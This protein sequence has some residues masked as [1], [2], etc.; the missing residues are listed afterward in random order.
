[1]GGNSLGPE[2]RHMIP[3]SPSLQS[4]CT[5]RVERRKSRPVS[6]LLPI[7]LYLAMTSLNLPGRVAYGQELSPA[8]ATNLPFSGCREDLAAD[9]ALTDP[10]ACISDR[11]TALR[12]ILARLQEDHEAALARVPG[13]L[14]SPG[15][16]SPHPLEP[17]AAQY[18]ESLRS[19]LDAVVMSLI[20]QSTSSE[21]N[22]AVLRAHIATFKEVINLFENL[23]GS[24][25]GPLTTEWNVLS[26]DQLQQLQERARA[27]LVQLQQSVAGIYQADLASA[28][29][30][31][32][33]DLKTY[34]GALKAEGASRVNGRKA[35][36]KINPELSFAQASTLDP[37]LAELSGNGWAVRFERWLRLNVQLQKA[38]AEK[39]ATLIGL[40]MRLSE[41]HSIDAKQRLSKNSKQLRELT[42]IISETHFPKPPPRGKPPEGSSGSI[43]PPQQPA[44]GGR[45]PPQMVAELQAAAEIHVKAAARG[46]QV[47]LA[48]SKARMS[49]ATR[50]FQERLGQDKSSASQ[51]LMAA[52]SESQL[53]AL[54]EDWRTYYTTAAQN[55]HGAII[56]LDEARVEIDHLDKALALRR[57]RDKAS[58]GPKDLIRRAYKNN[59]KSFEREFDL[60]LSHEFLVELQK[61]S[62]V[63]EPY[64]ADRRIPLL[65]RSTADNVLK[66]EGTLLA[67]LWNDLEES[68]GRTL[69]YGRGAEATK[70][71]RKLMIAREAVKSAAG[72][73]REKI[74]ARQAVSPNALQ[75]TLELIR[76][77]PDG[78]GVA[79]DSYI[80]LAEAAIYDARTSPHPTSN[81]AG[82]FKTQNSLLSQDI[83]IFP[84][85]GASDF[86][87]L[88]KPPFEERFP[89]AA[90]WTHSAAGAKA[91][92]ERAPGGII[93][94]A[95]M[96]RKYLGCLEEIKIDVR[97]G[98]LKIKWDGSWREMIPHVTAETARAAWAYVHDPRVIAIDMSRLDHRKNIW[99]NNTEYMVYNL[100]NLHPALTDRAIGLDLIRADKIIFGILNLDYYFQGAEAAGSIYLKEVLPD[101]QGRKSMIT[102]STVLVSPSRSSL[103]VSVDPVLEVFNVPVPKGRRQSTTSPL[104]KETSKWMTSHKDE[105][106][107]FFPSLDNVLT[108]AAVTAVFRSV[109]EDGI[110]NN[111]DDLWSVSEKPIST[112]RV[113]AKA[114]D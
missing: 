15:S 111:L 64:R 78:S 54:R 52:Q 112:P 114:Q 60:H 94:D 9:T 27:D 40:D 91:V 22:L 108:F 51:I 97:S 30:K 23:P 5:T 95:A 50:W 33:E 65:L 72:A 43:R 105:I 110:P 31:R 82:A 37:K 104:M 4:H 47:L 98:K 44:S 80:R 92:I 101:S 46:D 29:R 55:L 39:D 68:W 2:E 8:T 103:K 12:S 49:T 106:R 53:E 109:Y 61:L 11:V 36:R 6:W 41:L 10:H 75:D 63:T 24:D 102:A 70:V 62:D 16:L 89:L 71:A 56:T 73:V 99:L 100:V 76:R 7:F 20:D 93:I 88:T 79:T 42:A 96:P 13:A 74:R 32:I 77:I 35:L 48:W 85:G 57:A 87:G 113:W 107:R 86:A 38:H 26:D 58:Q 14:P 28:I 67:R 18:T 19:Q 25:D 83:Q 66:V 21:A 84:S 90:D 3:K 59:N 45:D 69:I 81:L 34:A 17:S 1:M